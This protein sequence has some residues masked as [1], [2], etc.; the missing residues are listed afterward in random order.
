[1][2]Q[3]VN[4]KHESEI[5]TSLKGHYPIDVPLFLSKAA[6]LDPQLKT[7]SF[8]SFIEREKVTTMINE[9]ETYLAESAAEDEL[10]TISTTSDELAEPPGTK[11]AKGG[12]ELFDNI[13]DIINCQPSE[14]QQVITVDQM[15]VEGML[16]FY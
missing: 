3:K 9:E 5:H 14:D 7:L 4:R 8:L 13:D 2:L 11:R 15:M 1:M 10:S 6:F 16:D 12:H